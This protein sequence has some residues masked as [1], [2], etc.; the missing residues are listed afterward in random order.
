MPHLVNLNEDPLMSECLLYQIKAGKTLVGNLENEKGADIRLSGGVS[1][2]PEHC[3]FQC[4]EDFKD[5]T[6]TAMEG[7]TTMVNGQRLHPNEVRYHLL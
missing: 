2:L 5:V 7:S 4:S 6:L 1:V 3:F